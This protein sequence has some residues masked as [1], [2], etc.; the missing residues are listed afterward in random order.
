MTELPATIINTLVT[1]T[2]VPVPPQPA[3]KPRM[4][5]FHP[6]WG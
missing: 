4:Y 1:L 2:Y 5:L 3:G 6:L